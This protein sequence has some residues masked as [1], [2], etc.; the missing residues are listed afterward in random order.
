MD[1]MDTLPSINYYGSD[2]GLLREWLERE[3]MDSYKGLARPDIADVE[4][5]Q[6]RGRIIFINQMLGWPDLYAAL[7]GPH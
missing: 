3:L 2:W 7:K 6:L 4:A 1:F 5:Q